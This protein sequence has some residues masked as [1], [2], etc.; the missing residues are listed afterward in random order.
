MPKMLL[1][2]FIIVLMVISSCGKGRP[3]QKILNIP[4]RDEWLIK[5]RLSNENYKQGEV[6]ALGLDGTR[7]RTVI[8]NNLQFG[9]NLPGNATYALYFITPIA[10][11]AEGMGFNN[12][13]R[14]PF[15]VLSFE[16]GTLGESET[17]RL[18]ETNFNPT[19]D[20]GIVDIK[21]NHA[22][23]ARSPSTLLDFDYDGILDVS[24]T[25]DQND[26]LN[27]KAQKKDIEEVIICT[28]VANS[29]YQERTVHLSE[30]LPY[31]DQGASMGP[32]PKSKG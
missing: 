1:T 31:L 12:N 28:A 29:H 22:Y 3:R 15:A 17:L 19:I 32:C 9:L 26:T 13:T 25:D 8:Q 24:D 11:M 7:Y 30:L 27:D 10:N 23:P 2:G 20:L 4:M 21:G 5:G 16:D 6:V 18:P 14:S